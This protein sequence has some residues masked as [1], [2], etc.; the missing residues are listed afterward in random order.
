LT[1][2]WTFDTPAKLE[3]FVPILEK[4][5]IAY[6]TSSKGKPKEPGDGIRVSVDERDFVKAKKLLLRH[7]KRRTSGD[8]L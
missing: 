7:R 2:L 3:L 5:G 1:V 6:E 8:S 4:H